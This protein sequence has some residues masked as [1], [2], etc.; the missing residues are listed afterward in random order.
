MFPR[1]LVGLMRS[2]VQ[3]SKTKLKSVSELDPA[4]LAKAR[5]LAL[6]VGTAAGAF[7]SLVGVG[8]GVLIGPVILNA[9]PAVPQRII[10]GTSLAAVATTGATAGAVYWSSDCVDAR[11]AAVLA[12]TAVLTAPFGAKMTHRV[13]CQRLRTMLGYW[14]YFVAPLV[15]LKAFLFSNQQEQQQQQQ[16]PQQQHEQQQPAQGAAA[17]ATSSPQGCWASSSSSSSSWGSRILQELQQPPSAKDAALAATGSLA[18][19]ASGMLGIGGG[20]VV[21]PL[22]ALATGAPQQV[23]LGTS[24]VAMVLPSVVGLAQ[25][26]RLGNVDW[27][28]AAALA[29]GTS[30]GSF[31]GSNFAVKAPAGVLEALFAAGMLLLGRRTLAAAGKGVPKAAQ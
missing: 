22:L 6:G 7:G 18:G 16:Q 4:L 9:C 29:V 5:Q 27:R 10:S 19:F 20:T 28:M 1:A 30:V 12:A 8:G 3:G 11:S 15:P 23:V 31:A 2:A 13:D 25:H 26:Q 17:A 21:T 14:L 24:L